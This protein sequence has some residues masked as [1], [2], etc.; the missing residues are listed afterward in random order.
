MISNCASTSQ[1]FTVEHKHSIHH[2]YIWY[3]TI[4]KCVVYYRAVIPY[5]NFL[6]PGTFCARV[7]VT[8]SITWSLWVH[9]YEL[10]GI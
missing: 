1:R 6:M 8:L 5:I 7:W 9:V 4:R 3:P 10:L 2:Y